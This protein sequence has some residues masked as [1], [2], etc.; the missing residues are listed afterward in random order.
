MIAL[1]ALSALAIQSAAFAGAASGS[2]SPP[3]NTSWYKSMTASGT[4]TG[5][6][7]YREVVHVGAGS[8]NGTKILISNKY[9]NK[10]L[11][12]VAAYIADPDGLPNVANMRRLTF[13]NDDK[14]VV[15]SAGGS[16][17]THVFRNIR[18]NRNYVVS[19]H[20]HGNGG[21][22]TVH[23]T[24]VQVNFV[25]NGGNAARRI[26]KSRISYS[27]NQSYFYLRA[28]RVRNSNTEGTVVAFGP[29]STDGYGSTVSANHRYPDYLANYLLARPAGKR[30]AVANAG[31]FGNQLLTDQAAPYGM[32]GV[33]R[34][35]DDVLSQPG[36]RYVIVW[37]G[38][39]DL[40]SGATAGQLESAY[41][42]L[43]SAAHQH[44]ITVIGATL[45]PTGATGER[46]VQRQAV[47]HWIR[48]S[49]AFNKAA[50]FDAVLRD[51]NHRN[52]IDPALMYNS[53]HPNDAGYHRVA[54]LVQK[55]IK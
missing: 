3:W 54:G 52:H 30:W 14:S 46:E 34:Y 6:L 12:V 49:G 44:G 20:V 37:E 15:I 42:T 4:K 2:T 55:L 53:A 27:N 19:L 17:L 28:V 33:H 24:G 43:I 25:S 8:T 32:S 10:P 51:P 9:G 35:Y 7:T 21:T 48:S 11:R 22:A 50:D 38:N 29:S 45:Q 47:N 5:N 39:N 16:A 40:G 41:R 23:R 13:R 1:C 18:A 31:L 36:V 26:W